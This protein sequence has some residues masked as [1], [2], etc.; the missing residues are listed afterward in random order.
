M[1]AASRC[2]PSPSHG[3][4]ANKNDENKLD[5]PVNFTKL[6]VRDVP[7]TFHGGK[8]EGGE[9]RERGHGMKGIG[10]EDQER[11]ANVQN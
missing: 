8:E 5:S 4:V 10:E 2:S 3:C 9:G 1:T 6:N 7:S 11:Q